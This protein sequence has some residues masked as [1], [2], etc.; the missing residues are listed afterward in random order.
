MAVISASLGQRIKKVIAR[1]FAEQTNFLGTLVRAR[2]NNPYTPEESTSKLGVEKQVGELIYQRLAKWGLKPQKLGASQARPNIVVAWGGSRARKS[3]LLNGH[4]DTVQPVERAGLVAWSGS[5]RGGK[6]Y[7]VGALDM[8]GPIS[9]YMYALKAL[10]DIGVKI[11]GR[12]TLAL[13]VDEE[14]GAVSRWGTAYV[15]NKGVRAKAAVIAEPAADGDKIGIG[16]RGGYRFKLITRGEGVHTGV[17]AWEKQEKGKNAIRDM[18]RVIEALQK[19]EIPFKPARAFPGRQPVFT[20]PTK[21]SGGT[22]INIVPETCT[23]YGDVRLMPGNSD[24]QVKLWM[25]EKLAHLGVDYEIE[26]LLFVPSVEI[27]SKEEIVQVLAEEVSGVMKV[28]PRLEGIGPWNDAWMLIKKDIP[29]V[30]QLPLRGGGAHGAEEW[31]DLASLRQL[32]EVLART[33]VRVLGMI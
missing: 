21:I 7:G 20:F 33:I 16:H 12:L 9:A 30:C 31:V 18:A 5:V 14:P 13:V 17:R 24:T 8:K 19:M 1:N 4:M 22:A 15:L 23:A 3:L 2:S 27:D 11:E 10:R 29:T 6:L 25:G 26:D 32:T 28:K